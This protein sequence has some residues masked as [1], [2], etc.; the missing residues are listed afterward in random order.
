MQIA[1]STR[2]IEKRTEFAFHMIYKCRYFSEKTKNRYLKM[3]MEPS[4]TQLD[5]LP[6]EILLLIFKNLFNVEVLYYL[7]DV[8]HRLKRIAHD[9]ILTSHLSLM[10]YSSNDVIHPLP[11]SILDRFCLKILPEIHRK[12]QWLNLE[13]S[14]MERILLTTNYPNLTRLGLYNIN[15]EKAQSIFL[16]KILHI[17]FS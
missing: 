16:G 13:S 14:S 17:C 2:L 1:I 10:K 15:I 8:N 3:N 6:D 4:C 12:V 5:D 9:S 11:K 7:T